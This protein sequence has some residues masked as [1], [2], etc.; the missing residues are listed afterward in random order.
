M[1]TVFARRSLRLR[2][3]L[4]SPAASRPDRQPS[5]SPAPGT[6]TR[7]RARRRRRSSATPGLWFV[8]TAEVLGR[9]QVVGERLPPR[10]QLDPGLHQ[11]RRLRRHVRVRHQGP[12]RDLRLVPGRHAHRSRP[13]PA[14]RATIRR[15]AASS[16]AIRASTSTGRGDNVGDFYLGA[17]FNLWSEYRQNP[18]AHRA[19]AAS[20][21]C[22]PARATP[23][24]A[25]AR[26]DCRGRSHRQQGSVEAGR[27]LRLR[28]LR[29]PRQPGRLR[30]ADRRLPLGRGRRVSRRATCCASPA[31]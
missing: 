22:R 19:C 28:R 9:R 5:T 7:P 30:R 6:P 17:K 14:L 13:P 24:P 2:V 8:P 26:P 27:G 3:A 1:T 29:V 25:P 18:A 12:R 10:H 31:S 21:S 16:I 15:S 11:R 23:A 20:S 4:L